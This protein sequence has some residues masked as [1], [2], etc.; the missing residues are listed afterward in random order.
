MAANTNPG[1]VD[2]SQA[3]TGSYDVDKG[4]LRVLGTSGNVIETLNTGGTLVPEHY[5]EI[6]LAYISSGP[7]AGEIGIVTYKL[8]SSTIAILTLS[9]DG[10]NRLIDVIRS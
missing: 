7:G 1:K 6:S 3:L 9:Y 8:A 10:S 5:D 2:L 4:A